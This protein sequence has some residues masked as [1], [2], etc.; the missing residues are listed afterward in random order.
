[1][2]KKFLSI[3]VPVYNAEK[4]LEKCLKSIVKQLNNNIELIL[5]N[6]GS[7]DN[8][9]EICKRYSLNNSNIIYIE[10]KN[11]G[12]SK[13]RNLGIDLAHGNY[14]WFIDSDDFIEKNSIE[15]ILIEL[16]EKMDVLIFGYKRV[17]KNKS[18]ES[19]PKKIDNNLDIYKQK[20]IFNS[21]C[22]KIYKKS[23]IKEHD[24]FFPE[25]SHMGEDMVFNFKYFSFCKNIKI[26]EETFY[27]YLETGGVTS[28]LSKKIEIF[29][30]FDELY[31][32][33]F[34]D[35]KIYEM[36][37]ILKDYYKLH[38]VKLPFYFITYQ[39]SKNKNIIK[40]DE[41]KKIE[42]EIEKRKEYFNTEFK[43]ER[44]LYKLRD[45]LYFVKNFIKK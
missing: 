28:S 27:N 30:S 42:K 40:R 37:N 23:L 41:F 7:K 31:K 35:N 3:I 14:I 38:A 5:I 13:T 36:K 24:I 32:F 29:Y 25:D 9:G 18:W 22:N 34:K 15:R 4:Y 26:L 12:C 11:E 44:Y 6:D 2:D 33:F 43:L 39:A 20:E 8:S 17:E 1:M 19:I 10:K 45:K 21:P 16:K